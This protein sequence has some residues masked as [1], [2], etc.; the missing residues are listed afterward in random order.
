MNLRKDHYRVPPEGRRRPPSRPS[1]NG[2]EKKNRSRRG[3]GRGEMEAPGRGARGRPAPPIPKRPREPPEER[4]GGRGKPRRVAGAGRDRFGRP[5][6]PPAPEGGTR[7]PAG[8]AGYRTGPA[9]LYPGG[10]RGL[11]RFGSLEPGRPLARGAPGRAPGR[12][13]PRRRGG[14]RPP[15]PPTKDPP[16]SGARK[17]A[18]SPRGASEETYLE[19]E[20]RA[21]LLA[22]DHSARASMKNAASCE[23]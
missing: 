20:Q 13:R 2:C 16:P 12:P 22:V 18:E 5:S 19:R 8:R 14:S 7:P 23:N 1:G 21:R 4:V 15:G 9:A 3:R 6:S 17:L 10:R 11:G